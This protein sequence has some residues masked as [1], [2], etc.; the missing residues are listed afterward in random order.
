MEI[1]LGTALW[2]AVIFG[3]VLSNLARPKTKVCRRCQ[4]VIPTKA[5]T[6]SYCRSSQPSTLGIYWPGAIKFGIATFVIVFVLMA[7][8]G[9]FS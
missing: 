3:C 6:C 2:A 9:L 5:D 4:R 1:A 7:F 8:A